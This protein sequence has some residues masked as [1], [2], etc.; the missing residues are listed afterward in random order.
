MDPW[1][2]S[3]YIWGDFHQ[4]FACRMRAVLNK[5]LP[6]GT[7]ARINSR[8]ST[9][10]SRHVFLEIRNPSMGHQL[11]TLI[12]FAT[13]LNKV[14]GPE[15]DFYLA[16]QMEILK[17]KVHLVVIDLLRAGKR[18]F[19]VQDG[20]LLDRLPKSAYVIFVSHAQ[21]RF[22]QNM[23]FGLWPVQLTEPLPEIPI[24]ISA[25]DVIA[26]KFQRIFDEAYDT[27][28]YRK[29]AVDYDKP[30][31][32]PLPPELAKWADECLRKAGVIA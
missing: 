12:E 30:P 2:E 1:L 7:Y 4:A 10:M 23:N 19:H 16:I 29:G 31:D 14:P 9:G 8:T 25:D 27:G 11:V 24:P 3:P 13:P 17:T 32:P 15:R 6:K 26:V 18:L 28:P 21:R 22:A 5:Y 20:K